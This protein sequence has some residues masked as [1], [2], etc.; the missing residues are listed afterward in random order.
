MPHMTRNV[1][2]Q[3]IRRKK[4]IAAL[5]LFI[6]MNE[7]SV[8]KQQR[9]T[10]VKSWVARR[11]AQGMH[12]NLFVELCLEDPY[13]FR[14]CLWMDTTFEELLHKIAPLIIKQDT[15]LRKS[16][17]SAERLSLT[18]KHIATGII[19]VNYNIYN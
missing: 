7:L 16:I 15:H 5:S 3:T 6:I 2:L 17:P 10:W 14:R 1:K 18:L 11:Q 9:S 19:S 13:K 12:H 8:D 4:K